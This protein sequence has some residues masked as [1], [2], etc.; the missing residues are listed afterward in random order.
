MATHGKTVKLLLWNA[1]QVFTWTVLRYVKKKIHS[2]FLF[3]VSK[4]KKS[5]DSYTNYL[6]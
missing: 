1:R 4:Y 2:H 3:D 6:K 5:Q